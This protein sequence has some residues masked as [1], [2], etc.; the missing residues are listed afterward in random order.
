MRAVKVEGGVYSEGAENYN[1]FMV[2]N[3][4]RLYDVAHGFVAETISRR[5]AEMN[6]PVEC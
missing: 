4:I 1:K 5:K 2:Q 6:R 3:V